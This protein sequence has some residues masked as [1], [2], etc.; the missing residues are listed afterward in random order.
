MFISDLRKSST[1]SMVSSLLFGTV[2]PVAFFYLFGL[3]AEAFVPLLAASLVSAVATFALLYFRQI[4]PLNYS[5]SRTRDMLKAG[6]RNLDEGEGKAGGHPEE[7]TGVELDEIARSIR[8][9]FDTGIGAVKKCGDIA[10]AGAEVSYAADMLKQR[11]QTQVSNIQGIAEST[12]SISRNIEDAVANSDNLRELSRL[13]RKASYT[14]QED[15]TEAREQLQQTSVHARQAA[16]L[17]VNLESRSGQISEI[18]KV[19]S[20]IADQTNLLALNAAIEAARAGEQGRGFAVVAEEVRNL[21]TR[22]ASSTSEIGDMVKQINDETGNA[23]ETMRLLL[24]DVDVSRHKTEKVNDQ[25]EE[26]LKHAREVEQRVTAA[27]E[28]SQQDRSYQL[29]ISSAVENLGVSLAESSREVESVSSQSIRLSDM[30]ESIYELYGD[31]GLQGDHEAVFCEA[32]QA[33]RAIEECFS[34]AA[35]KGLLSMEDLFDTD[36]RPIEGSNP[37]KFHSRFDGFTDKTLPSIQEPILSRNEF[38]AYAGAVDRNGYFPTHN[39]RYSQPLTG[40]YEKDLLSNRTKRIFNDRTGAR[41]GANTKPFL[42]QTYKRDTGEVM[43]DLSLPIQ[44]DGRHWGGF[45][46]GYKSRSFRDSE[47]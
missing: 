32:K 45:R 47:D 9:Q 2:A 35:R 27:A 10:I 42:L 19:I 34:E 33:V 7:A 5:I 6:G 4:R 26:I 37:P 31:A 44:V 11:I 14:G 22:T 1:A 30:T 28:R 21:A 23:A 13:T 39:K 38:I 25:L 40:N 43:H 8:Q 17:I 24:G 29:Q 15:I 36:Y 41:V 18:T 3:P 20:E 16:D 12:A 46:I